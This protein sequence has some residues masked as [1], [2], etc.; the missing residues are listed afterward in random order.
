MLRLPIFGLVTPATLADAA[1]ALRTPGARLV[2]GGTDLL[3]NLKHRLEGPPVLVS[4]AGVRE[5]RAI[6]RDDGAGVLRIGA[7][8]TLTEISEHADVVAT[9]PSLAWAAGHIASPLIR[10]MGT[11]GG[12]VN[13]DT[14]CRYVNQT[15]FWRSAIGGCLKSEGNVCHVVPGGRNCVAAMSSDCVPVLIGLDARIVLLG[16]AGE[17]ELPLAEYYQADGTRHTLRKDDEI[18]TELRV[19]LPTSPRRTSYVKWAVRKSIDYPLLSIALRFDL[20]ADSVDAAIERISI[21][22]GVLGARPREV[23]RLEDLRGRALSDPGVAAAVSDRVHQQ[24]KPLENVPY[25]APYRREMLRVRTR[26]AI[27]ELVKTG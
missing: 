10:N 9:F 18:T 24:C 6:T 22:V 5:L 16:S 14:R 11:L 3:P 13:L 27:A 17:R 21:V 4:L 2:A 23:T 1:L 12:N 20:A 8:A 7:G 15:D 26:R 19:P 25:E